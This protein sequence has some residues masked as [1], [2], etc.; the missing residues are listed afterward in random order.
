MTAGLSDQRATVAGIPV[1]WVTRTPEAGGAGRG[2]A[3]WLPYLG[4]TKDVVLP[5]LERLARAGFFAVSLDPWQ[6]GDRGT[7]PPE[8]LRDR[9]LG[10][11]RRDMWPVIG[12]T[13]LDAMWVLDWVIGH[14]DVPAD[15]VVA[16]GLSMGGD[17]S[18]A[19]AGID[20][21]VSRVAALGSTPDWARPGMRNLDG[22][23]TLVDQGTPSPYGRWLYDQL[24]PATHL[25]RYAHGP[26]ILFENGGDDDHVP[27]E[28]AHRF[29]AALAGASPAA[30]KNVTVRVSEGLAH[31][32]SVRNPDAVDRCV[33]WLTEG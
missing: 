25:E 9:M 23:G 7:E 24:N 27:V 1:R 21:R 18:V 5:V 17:I 33:R 31:V 32:D 30:G 20:H 8:Q 12:H 11:F 29:A 19:L 28:N 4:G 15:D 10:S 26:A 16:G 2:I 6:H 22:S 14:H 3:L 13:T